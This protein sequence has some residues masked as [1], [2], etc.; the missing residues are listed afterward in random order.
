MSTETAKTL[1]L[2]K[3][4]KVDLTKDNPSLKKLSFGLGWD[5]QD[6]KTFDLDAFA[7]QAKVGK[8]L[9][10]ADVG[11]E[12]GCLCFFNNLKIKGITHSGDN[13]TGAG[14]GDDETITVDLTALPAD[15][16]EVYLGLNIYE[17]PDATM[18]QVK[19]AFCRAYNAEDASK[20][21]I[22]KFDLS[23]DHGAA[24]GLVMGRLY[25]HNGE[26]KFEA[27]GKPVSGDIFQIVD[28]Y[29]HS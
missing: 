16:E 4:Q 19:N 17:K 9:T 10:K 23:E 20:T 26:W 25:K 3:D 2:S 13:R 15:C 22:I 7:W 5:L 14:D 12:G 8:P 24:K 1:T 27:I 21:S 18:G 11:G 29:T 6:G 28:S